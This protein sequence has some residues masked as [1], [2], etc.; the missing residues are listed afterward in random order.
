M[1]F[2]FTHQIK[3]EELNKTTDKR[4][5][6]IAITPFEVKDRYTNYPKCLEDGFIS[7]EYAF[8]N[9]R[10]LTLIYSRLTL[11]S[12]RLLS[13]IINKL[14]I[15][16]NICKFRLAE[17]NNIF[18]SAV[19][20]QFDE[21][22]EPLVRNNIIIRTNRKCTYIIN[23]N[24]FFKGDLNRFAK[25]YKEIYGNRKVEYNEKGRVIIDG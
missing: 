25:E 13:I 5:G 1:K 3:L 7:E 23:H 4:K 17:F 21:Y 2:T 18:S 11:I 10:D 12:I 16:S 9:V 24:M 14:P 20:H 19:K 6:K 15:N 8:V 22:L